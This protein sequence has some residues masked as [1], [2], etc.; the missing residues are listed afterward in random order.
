[1]FSETRDRLLDDHELAA[2]IKRARST[3]QKDR[4]K[5]CGV[6]Y[7]K[8]GALVRYRESDVQAYI[9]SLATHH[10]TSEADQT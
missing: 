3:I 8:V 9:A 4:L 7:I 1:M 5:G 10:S 2:R 6:P